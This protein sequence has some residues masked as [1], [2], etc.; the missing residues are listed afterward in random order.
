MAVDYGDA[1]TGV[2][3]CDEGERLASPV[4]VIWQRDRQKLLAELAKTAADQ[5]AGEV[6]VGNPLN[7][8]GTAG[9]RSELCAEF[10][11][12]LSKTCGLPVRLWDERSTTVT[13]THYLNLTDTRGKK[14]K[15]VVDAVAATII[16]EGYLAYR[17]N[18]ATQG[19]PDETL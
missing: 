13:A 4:G 16:L 12:L 9:P 3:V 17:K 8:N 19:V 10:A 15:G 7:M 2:A 1:R 11:A 14:R 6:I 5:R 18:H